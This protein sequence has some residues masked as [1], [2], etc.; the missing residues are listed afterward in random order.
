[1][2]NL[3]KLKQYLELSFPDIEKMTGFSRSKIQRHYYGLQKIS[4]EDAAWY[5]KKLMDK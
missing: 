3:P 4:P 1:M 5:I 2:L